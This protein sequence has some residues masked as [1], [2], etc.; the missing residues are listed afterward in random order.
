MDESVTPAKPWEK[1]PDEPDEAYVRFMTYCALG[2]GRSMDAAYRLQNPVAAKSGKSRSKKP[3]DERRASGQWWQNSVEF[4]WTERAA[5]YDIDMLTAV[6][7]K[8][9]ARYVSAVDLALGKILSALLD[10][11][12]KPRSWNQ[13][14]ESL[15]IVGSFI[16]AETVSTIRRDFQ[17]D[18]VP[19]IGAGTANADQTPVPAG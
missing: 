2:P 14:I 15:T 7:Q 19:A 17:D 10:E 13:T 1:L 9:V 8:A 6:A 4:R 18:S 16:P 11:K 5:A 3:V 12:I